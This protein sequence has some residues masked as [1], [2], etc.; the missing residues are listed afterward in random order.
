MYGTGDRAAKRRASKI[1]E[2]NLKVFALR[3]AMRRA[4]K[5]EIGFIILPSPVANIEEREKGKVLYCVLAILC[6]LGNARDK[7]SVEIS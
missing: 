7:D 4:T 2:A 3:K 1:H 6:W 5:M